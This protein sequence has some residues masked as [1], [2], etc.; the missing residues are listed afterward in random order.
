MV[1]GRIFGAAARFLQKG[2]HRALAVRQPKPISLT[3]TAQKIVDRDEDI[4][5]P[6]ARK[7]AELIDDGIIAA[8]AIDRQDPS[9]PIEAEQIPLNQYGAGSLPLGDRYTVEI[10]VIVF[11][12][13]GEFLRRIAVSETVPEGTTPQEMEEKA[14][15]ILEKE[16]NDSPAMFGGAKLDQLNTV[17]NQIIYAERAF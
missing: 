6:D 10:E 11:D 16:Y 1:L 15:E 17:V 2:L 14:Q 3:Q 7:I 9:A 12:E 8:E 13:D 4:T 5:K